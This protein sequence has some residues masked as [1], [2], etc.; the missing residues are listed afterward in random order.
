LAKEGDRAAESHLDRDARAAELLDVAGAI[1]EQAR[2]ARD[3]L[4]TVLPQTHRGP[5]I[6]GPAALQHFFR[7][8]V[9]HGSAQAAFQKTSRLEVGRP[10]WG[11]GAAE[12]EALGLAGDPTL[13]LG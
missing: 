5:V 10:I 13:P 7:P 8:V 3:G 11:E 9:G 1:A 4:R 2:Y 12:G 6:F